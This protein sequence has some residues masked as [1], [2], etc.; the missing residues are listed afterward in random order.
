MPSST[1]SRGRSG[2]SIG[3]ATYVEV[4]T[5]FC[6]ST[7]RTPLLR[8]AGQRLFNGVTQQA[9][10]LLDWQ[11]GIQA[12]Q[13]KGVDHRLVFL[14]NTLLKCTKARDRIPA[15]SQVHASLIIL[16]VRM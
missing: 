14:Q 15:Q 1:M 8:W 2:W 4:P 9:L 12:Q 10:L 13:S 16:Q 11:G 3:M 5:W 7:R 6:S